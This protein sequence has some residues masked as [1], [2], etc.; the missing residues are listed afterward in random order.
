MLLNKLL[1]NQLMLIIE[2]LEGWFA[3]LQKLNPVVSTHTGSFG[4]LHVFN[5][6]TICVVTLDNP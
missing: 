2:D 4:Y 3:Q 6:T 1:N 5:H